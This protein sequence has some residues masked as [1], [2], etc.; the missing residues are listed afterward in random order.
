[1]VVKSFYFVKNIESF[2]RGNFAK[3]LLSPG[4]SYMFLQNFENALLENLSCSSDISF[5]WKILCVITKFWT[6]SPWKFD[7]FLLYFFLL[8][9]C[10]CSCGILRKLSWKFWCVL[11]HFAS[12]GK[13]VCVLVLFSILLGKMVCS[14]KRI[15]SSHG[16]FIYVFLLHPSLLEN[17]MCY[18]NLF[19]K[20]SPGKKE[21]DILAK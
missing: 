16:K 6:R 18:R 13:F 14:Y 8:E 15:M 4:K 17:L 9:N 21:T 12:P 2:R 19:K 7:L 1:M 3:Y 10:M 11:V 20:V 5:P